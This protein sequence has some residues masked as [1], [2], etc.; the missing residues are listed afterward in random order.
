MLWYKKLLRRAEAAKLTRNKLTLVENLVWHTHCFVGVYRS[1]FGVRSL[2]QSLVYVGGGVLLYL[3]QL[4]T[5]MVGV[6]GAHNIGGIVGW[7]FKWFCI[8]L[9]PVG[10]F[11]ALPMIM[12]LIDESFKKK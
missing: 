1:V 6:A 4:P 3:F 10:W 8:L 12:Y 2:K 5:V 9:F 7:Y 11:V